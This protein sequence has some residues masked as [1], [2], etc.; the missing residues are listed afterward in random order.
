MNNETKIY[1]DFIKRNRIKVTKWGY[2]YDNQDVRVF[3]SDESKWWYSEIS[4]DNCHSK[5][6]C[7]YWDLHNRYS[8]KDG[9]IINPK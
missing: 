2:N 7:I 8:V 3:K 1:S 6:S 5:K 4:Q 9:L